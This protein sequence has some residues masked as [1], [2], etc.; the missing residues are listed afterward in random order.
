MRL[1]AI[2]Q[3]T[4]KHAHVQISYR[5]VTSCPAYRAFTGLHLVY[6]YLQARAE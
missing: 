2:I 3:L 4:I 5:N 6:T 1:E